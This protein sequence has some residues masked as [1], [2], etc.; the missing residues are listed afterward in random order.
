MDIPFVVF[1]MYNAMA[2]S[3]GVMG[4]WL[5]A[6]GVNG[7][8]FITVLSGFLFLFPIILIDDIEVDYNWSVNTTYT[9]IT[10]TITETPFNPIPVN[11]AFNQNDLWVFSILLGLIFV[12]MGIMLQFG[13]FRK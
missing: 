5:G 11:Y 9:N 2:I 1:A 7:A 13:D 8:P 3:I 12:F 10:D 6:K 4:I